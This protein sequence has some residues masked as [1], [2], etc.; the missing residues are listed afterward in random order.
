MFTLK[1]CFETILSCEG[2]H[3]T[4]NGS[5]LFSSCIH[6]LQN[7]NALTQVADTEKQI[8]FTSKANISQTATRD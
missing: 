3:S 1:K 7:T 6:F 2:K 5:L 4:L 8:N